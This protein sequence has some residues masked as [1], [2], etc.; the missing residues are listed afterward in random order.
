MSCAKDIFSLAHRKD[1]QFNQHI[2]NTN[3]RA[4]QKHGNGNTKYTNTPKGAC[5]TNHHQHHIGPRWCAL[6]WCVHHRW[7]HNQAVHI[8]RC[9]R[10]QRRRG[11]ICARAQ[12]T[13]RSH[14]RLYLFVNVLRLLLAHARKLLSARRWC[15]AGSGVVVVVVVVAVVLVN[16]HPQCARISFRSISAARVRP[17][18]AASSQA[19]ARG[20]LVMLDCTL[21]CASARRTRIR[22]LEDTYKLCAL[23]NMCRMH[24][25]CTHKDGGNSPLLQNG[26][27]Q[28]YWWVRPQHNI[29]PVLLVW[30]KSETNNPLCT[31]CGAECVPSTTTNH[32]RTRRCVEYNVRGI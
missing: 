20:V 12:P 32:K 18:V 22:A 4:H 8:P 28:P 26:T 9:R 11:L 1:T 19:R 25:A 3:A 16:I 10:Q 21:R 29:K 15:V 24:I 7:M 13:F 5:N 6:R 2:I 14:H 23:A 30:F 31:V 27:Q 17:F